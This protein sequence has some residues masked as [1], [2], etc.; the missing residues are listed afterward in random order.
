MSMKTFCKII[1]RQHARTK[2]LINASLD[3]SIEFYTAL[4]EYELKEMPSTD[5]NK[6]VDISVKLFLYNFMLNTFNKNL[7]DKYIY[8]KNI[9]DNQFINEEIK[10]LFITHICSAQK[11]Y[12]I[13]N[14]WVFKYKY[15]RLKPHNDCDLYMNPI[16]E[17]QRNVVAVLQNGQKYLFAINDIVNLVDNALCC[18][19]LYDSSPKAAKNPYNNIP[20]NKAILCN[21]YLFLLKRFLKV[22][23]LIQQ[24]FYSGFNLTTFRNNNEFL[25]RNTFVDKYMRGCDYDKM[26]RHVN[27]MLREV[28][29]YGKIMIDPE[30]PREKLMKIM[31]PYVELYIKY[32]YAYSNELC[33]FYI[34][35]LRKRLVRL[36]VHNPH[37]GRKLM[38]VTTQKMYI[39]DKHPVY[40]NIQYFRD[41]DVSHLRL[42]HVPQRNNFNGTENFDD[43]EDH[44]DDE[45]S[46]S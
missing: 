43:I 6:H 25:I 20:F 42:E 38:N 28:K 9:L 41:F 11:I 36:Y 45:G 16:I 12:Q 27:E 23:Q 2:E 14:R 8:I 44:E 30:F 5:Q 3:N 1:H 37:F 39:N 26:R 21:I 35:E 15:K 4:Y 29:Y 40:V 22:P 13:L 17:H 31:Y 24:Y 18:M 33:L 7:K 32:M 46:M 10:D 34:R 19:N